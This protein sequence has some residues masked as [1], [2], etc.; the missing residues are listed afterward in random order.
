MKDW[1]KASPHL[2]LSFSRVIH[3]SS[4]FGASHLGLYWQ[5]LYS[6][7]FCCSTQTLD[8]PG[9]FATG[10]RTSKKK[11]PYDFHQS[12]S[13]SHYSQLY[14]PSVRVSRCPTFPLVHSPI[15]HH[16]TWN[17]VQMWNGEIACWD[18]EELRGPVGCVERE[19]A[20]TTLKFVW[21][22]LSAIWCNVQ[23]GTWHFKW[24]LHFPDERDLGR[25]EFEGVLHLKPYLTAWINSPVFGRWADSCSLLVLSFN[26]H[27]GSLQPRTISYATI[28]NM[29]SSVCVRAQCAIFLPS[30]LARPKVLVLWIELRVHVKI[31][32]R[33]PSSKTYIFFWNTD[34]NL[35]GPHPPHNSHI[36]KAFQNLWEICGSVRAFIQ[37]IYLHFTEKKTLEK[38][39][40]VK[41]QYVICSWRGRMRKSRSTRDCISFQNPVKT[42][43]NKTKPILKMCF[44]W[45]TVKNYIFK[46]A[47]MNVQQP[48]K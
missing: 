3:L 2:S 18:S 38:I 37:F 36:S 41:V 30:T 48:N 7:C 29:R 9:S 40:L 17:G 32:C 25:V 15:S 47:E 27:A 26:N 22:P 8:H 20:G 42:K 5:S 21:M 31:N 11:W 14:F 4:H 12:S 43:Q 13:Y 1:V 44:I 24:N 10:T 6:S 28:T 23:F 45:E 35:S 19:V 46:L 34:S 16:P 39:S 33:S